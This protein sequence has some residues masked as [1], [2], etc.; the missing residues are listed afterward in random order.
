MGETSEPEFVKMNPQKTVPLLDDNGFYLSESRA[1]MFYLVNARAP[2]SA[3]LGRFPKKRA[4]IH[5]R[6]HFELGT[7]GP[8]G[9]KIIRGVLLD[10]IDVIPQELKDELLGA[11]EIV[12]GYLEK[13]AYIADNFISIADFSYL[14]AISTFIVS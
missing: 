3:L 11:L 14:A 6:L 13:N 2:E 9:R 1:I 4:M 7:L 8:I 10:E 12:N 5:Q